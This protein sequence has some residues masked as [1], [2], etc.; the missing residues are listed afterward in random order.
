MACGLATLQVLEDEDLVARARDTGAELLARLR[1]LQE[2]HSLIKEVRGLG[3]MIAVEFHEPRELAM[4]M[5]WK[6][7]HRVEAELFAQMIVTALFTRHR[8]LTQIAGHGMDVLKILPPLIIGPREIDHFIT[9]LDAV[10]T[11]CRTFPGPL[12]ELG[13]NFVRHALKRGSGGENPRER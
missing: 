12:W 2:K 4:K 5:G 13:A 7:L 9:S 11:D 10:L 3:L 8:I 1:Q 6:L